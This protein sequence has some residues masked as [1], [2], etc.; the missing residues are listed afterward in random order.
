MSESGFSQRFNPH[1]VDGRW[2]KKWEESGCFHAKDNSDRPHS[3]ILEMF[4]YPSGRIHMGHVRNYTMGDVLARYYRMK[5]HEVLHPMGWDAFGMPAENAAMERKIHPREWTMSNIA[6]MREQLKRIGF[7]IDWSRELA[8]CEPS[9]Y[10]QEQALFLDLYKAGLVYRKESAVNWDPIDNTVLANEQVIDGRGW[11]SGALVERKKLNQWFLKITEF[12]DDLLD[13]LKDLDQ[14]PEKVRSMQENWIGRSQGMQFHFNF[15]VA[16]EG[17]DKIEVFTT[18]PDTLFGASFVAIACDH[19]IAKALAEKNAALPEFIADCQKMGTAAEDIETAEKKGFDTGLSLVHP[20]NPELKLPLFVANFVLMDYGTG[21]VF[22]CPAHDQRDLD[23]ALKYNLPVKRVV[24]PSEAESNEAIGDKADTRAGIMVNSSFL[25]GLS[26]EEAKKTVIARAEK[27]GWGKGTTVFRLRDWGVSRQRYWGTP[28]P[29]IHCDSCGAVPVP[30]DQLPVTLPDDINFD[31][32]GNPLERHPTWKNVTCPKCGKPARRETDTL[33]TFVDSSWYFIRFASQPDDKPFDK[34][35]AE[36][37]LPVG[38]YIGGVEHAILHL[39]YAR[40]WTRALQSIGRLDIKEPFTG[41]FTQGMVTHETY[42][43]P[44]GHWLSPEQIHK[45]EAGI[46]LTESG[47]KVTVGRVEKMSKSKKNVV[48]PAP[49]LDQYGADAVRWFM[50]SDSPP[51]RDLAWTEAGIEG[52]WRFMQRLWRVA[53]IASEEASAGIDKDLQHRLHCSIKE[54]GE[55]IEGLSFNKAIAKIHDLVNA[56]EKAKASATRKEAALTL[57]RLV[58]PM[59]PHLSEEA[60]HLL[61]KEGFVAE[62]SWPEFDPALTVEDEITIAVQV[63]GKLRDTLTV[64]RDMPKD[65]AEKLALASEKVIKMLEGRSP[66]KV[67]VVPNRLVNIV[68]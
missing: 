13:G 1:V 43:D 3:Y 37:W 18:R 11:R 44:E 56:I 40:F 16:P 38:Q 66:K 30:K 49:I 68:A 53:A 27:E 5:G 19:P 17:F 64:A 54:V 21:A 14:W 45:D 33:D 8:T 32:P 35:T 60:W 20:L 50:L 47:E 23:F 59:V 25:D 42:K 12:A 41:L 31:K 10:G 62:A 26:S 9:Y 29:I 57:F 58:A 2:Q 28:I 6:T 34:A 65:E 39:L 61:E 22:G 48:E 55:A 51:E 52:C 36:K 63:N 46:F 7:A 67:I 4:P 15:E 24:A